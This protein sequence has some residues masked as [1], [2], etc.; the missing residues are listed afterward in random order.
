MLSVETEAL[1][2]PIGEME[3][4]SGQDVGTVALSG[5]DGETG[6]IEGYNEGGRRRGR[7]VSMSLTSSLE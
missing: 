7:P 2:G 5:L 1:P 4:L 3:T 6:V